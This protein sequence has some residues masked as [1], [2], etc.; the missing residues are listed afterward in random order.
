MRK[1]NSLKDIELIKSEILSTFPELIKNQSFPTAI[2]LCKNNLSSISGAIRKYH[3][4]ASKVA[5]LMGCH[6]PGVF[7]ATDGHFVN[8]ANE[9]ELDEFL[10]SRGINHEHNKVITNDFKYRYDFKISINNKIYFIEIWGFNK[11]SNIKIYKCYGETRRKKEELY[12]KLN[13]NLIS[14]EKTIFEKSPIELENYLINLFKSIGCNCEKQI[15]KYDITTSPRLYNMNTTRLL[16][17][18]VINTLGHFP[19]TKDLMK[20]KKSTLSY[21]MQKF[22]GVRYWKTQFNFPV[23]IF[24]NENIILD[25]INKIITN[26]GFL[27][28]T[29]ELHKMGKHYANLVNAMV[30]LHSVNYYRQKTNQKILQESPNYYNDDTIVEKIHEVKINLGYFPTNQEIDNYF[31][32][33]LSVTFWR[34]GGMSKF[35]KLHDI[36]YNNSN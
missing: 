1:I 22:G 11:D 7:K 35:R 12:S 28:S 4:G 5:E 33:K 3:G 30:K 6:I 36:K 32:K 15:I 8:S 16:L 9:Y 18:E 13:L 27:P 10:Y 29:V 17:G 20:I 14:I 26:L 2:M 25:E 34:H 31:G 19:T 21:A 23:T 24:W